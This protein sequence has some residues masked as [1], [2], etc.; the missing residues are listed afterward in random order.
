G[1]WNRP[2]LTADKFI[3]CPFIDGERMYRTGDL[4]R[5]NE[6]GE[7]E[8]LGRIDTQVKLRGFRIELGEIESRAIQFDAIQSAVAEVKTVSQNQM[9][10]LYYTSENEIS[11]TVL[12]T[13]FA[14]SFADYM[15]PTFYMRLDSMPLT[16]NGKV[17]RKVLPMPTN[18]ITVKNVQPLNDLEARVLEI[19]RELLPGIEFGVTDDL[20]SVGM[21]S[22]LAMRFVS[23]LHSLHLNIRVPMVMVNRTI[24]SI[25]NGNRELFWFYKKY[26]ALKPTL[27][28]VHGI[29]SLSA[30]LDKFAIWYETFNIFVF[31]PTDSHFEILFENSSYND[32]V[33]FYL[34]ILEQNLPEDVRLF[35]FMGF[36]WGGKIAYNLAGHWSE[37]KGQLPA[38]IM[39]DT[40]FNNPIVEE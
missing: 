17:N 31:E 19:A 13:F 15:I 9:L 29:V 40:Y 10:C 37:L 3:N 2:D 23:R 30:T 34:N 14:D 25:L 27:V 16:P 8:Y 5:W 33:H 11:E 1:Y 24:R 4:V 21:N 39:G 32:V 6:A 38:V 20:F 26:D 35:G 22:L 12:R 28:F 18:V 36:S 7:L